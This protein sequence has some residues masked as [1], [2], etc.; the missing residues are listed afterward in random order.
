MGTDQIHLTG[1]SERYQILRSR[2]DTHLF[3]VCYADRFYDDV[4][5]AVRNR[6]P[7]AGDRGLVQNLRPEIRLALARDCYMVVETPEAVFNPET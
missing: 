3:V 4:P 6:G 1:A 2:N 7:W 5:L